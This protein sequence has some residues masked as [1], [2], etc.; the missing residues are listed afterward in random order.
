M[1]YGLPVLA[2]YVVDKRSYWLPLN[3]WLFHPTAFCLHM[4][5]NQRLGSVRLCTLRQY[6]HRVLSA[7]GVTPSAPRSRIVYTVYLVREEKDVEF[8]VPKGWD[9]CGHSF[10]HVQYNGERQALSVTYSR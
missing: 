10:H 7:Q 9:R 4:V 2:P 3:L 6:I 1:A 8:A 5:P